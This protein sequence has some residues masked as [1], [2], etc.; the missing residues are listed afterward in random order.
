VKTFQTPYVSSNE[1]NDLSTTVF[2]TMFLFVATQAKSAVK[3]TPRKAVL[4]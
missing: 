3:D 4:K 1:G 2:A